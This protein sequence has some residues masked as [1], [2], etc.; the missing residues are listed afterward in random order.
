MADEFLGKDFAAQTFPFRQPVPFGVSANNAVPWGQAI[1]SESFESQVI[2]TGDT[3]TLSIDVELPSDYVSIL[4][5]MHLGCSDPSAVNWTNGVMGLAYQQP[6]GPYKTSVATYPESQ[7]LWWA[8]LASQSYAI[9]DRF[10]S[11]VNYKFW[12]IG[13]APGSGVS[14][15]FQNANVLDTPTEIPLWIPPQ[16]D[17]S[18]QSRSMILYVENETASSAANNFVFNA[19][20]DLYTL[21]QAYASGVMSSPRVF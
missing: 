12:T 7:Y 18:L 8:L 16:T 9:R 21:E 14:S 5:S 20:F 13:S 6:G 4:R 11:S 19:V 2:G 1:V 3:G 10:S 15:R 17:S